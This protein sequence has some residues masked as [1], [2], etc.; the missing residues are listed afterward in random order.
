MRTSDGESYCRARAAE[1]E[2]RAHTASSP[3]VK[4]AFLKIKQRWLQSAYHA[5]AE[6]EKRE[7]DGRGATTA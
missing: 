4:A 7:R 3:D 6:A 1:C 5:E 2:Q